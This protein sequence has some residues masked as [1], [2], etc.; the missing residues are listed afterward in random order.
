M[1][2]ALKTIQTQLEAVILQIKAT[3]P[4]DEPF[5]IAHNN[6]SFPG[7]T[8]SELIEEAKSII[9]LIDD[10]G[11]NEL[12]NSEGR[13]KDYVRRITYLHGSTVPNIWGN[14]GAAIPTY[15]L[16]LE[17]LRKAL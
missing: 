13:I 5:G 9:E 14:A 17:G 1:H 10:S 15:M 8:R 4:N 11:T 2:E 7:L 16:T 12:G 3:V 6:W